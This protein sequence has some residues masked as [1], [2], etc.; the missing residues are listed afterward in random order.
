MKRLCAFSDGTWQNLENEMPTNVVILMQALKLSASDGVYQVA[1]Y[2]EGIGGDADRSID[3]TVYGAV[4]GGIMRNIKELYRQI[5]LNYQDGDEVYLF[6]FSR[7]AF[8]IRSLANFMYEIGL[9]PRHRVDLI[10][11]AYELYQK[12]LGVDHDEVKQFRRD[13]GVIQVPVKLVA[14]FDTVASLGL[15]KGVPFSK[16]MA[17]TFEHH[18]HEL[19][20]CVD[21]GIHACSIDESRESFALVEMDAAHSHQKVYCNYFPG[22]HGAV[23]GGTVEQAPLSNA[24]LKWMVKT[25]HDDA[26]IPLEFDLTLVPYELVEDPCID[27]P[28]ENKLT[29]FIRKVGGEQARGIPDPKHVHPSCLARWNARGDYRPEAI[30]PHL[31][32]LN[33]KH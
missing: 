29:K 18:D 3:K 7:G 14:C 13:F 32:A 6:G 33:L 17:R 4:G 9:V 5:A 2:D 28:Q 12:D 26:G 30:T 15:P 27:F 21:Y 23:G 24:A 22:G 31:A 11:E 10:D 19:T 1:L 16:R 25:I 8:T 20:P